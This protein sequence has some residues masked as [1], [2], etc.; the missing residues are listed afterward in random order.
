MT[1]SKLTGNIQPLDEVDKINEIID[2]VNTNTT[3]IASKQNTLVS[4]TNIKTINNE[5][6]LGSGNITIDSG[7]SRNIGE[8]VASTIPLHGTKGT[9]HLCSPVPMLLR[10]TLLRSG[11]RSR[12]ILFHSHCLYH[13]K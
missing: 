11:G 12:H 9:R 10:N 13:L 6:I 2:G 7:S 4:G 8:I 5:S 1:I 3:S